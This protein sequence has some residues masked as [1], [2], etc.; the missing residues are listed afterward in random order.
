MIEATGVRIAKGND[1][2]VDVSAWLGIISVNTP[3]Q[4]ARLSSLFW[5]GSV[6]PMGGQ[7]R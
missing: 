7:Y 4:T 1:A 3:P 2:L 5:F 6:D